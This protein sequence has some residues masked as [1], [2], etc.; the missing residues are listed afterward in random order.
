MY[1]VIFKLQNKSN[2]VITVEFDSIPLPT[3][4]QFFKLKEGEQE[5]IYQIINLESSVIEY[6]KNN[7]KCNV[8]YTYIFREME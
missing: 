1:N 7:Y 6:N 4:H 8:T 3:S 5:R 2:D